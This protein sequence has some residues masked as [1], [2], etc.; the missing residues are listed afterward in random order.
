MIIQEQAVSWGENKK[1]KKK[2]V[3]IVDKFGG[4]THG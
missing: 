2:S 1:A 4:F 3:I